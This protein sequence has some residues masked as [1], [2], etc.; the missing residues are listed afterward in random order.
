M[1]ILT[2][3]FFKLWKIRHKLSLKQFYEQLIVEKA[4]EK[5]AFF[6]QSIYT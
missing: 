6:P 2:T 4:V 1:A 5:P 3:K